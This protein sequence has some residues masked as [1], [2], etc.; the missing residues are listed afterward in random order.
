[1]ITATRQ[2]RYRGALLGLAAGDALV[3][4]PV[5]VDALAR[6]PG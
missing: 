4:E 2:N 3:L 5:A 6:R 1:M